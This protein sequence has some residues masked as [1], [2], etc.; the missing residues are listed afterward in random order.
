MTFAKLS[1]LGIIERADIHSKPVDLK[2]RKESAYSLAPEIV[3]EPK[4]NRNIMTTI[5][6]IDTGSTLDNCHR[7]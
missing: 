4:A 6:I 5:V 3:F 7:H 1:L 2:V